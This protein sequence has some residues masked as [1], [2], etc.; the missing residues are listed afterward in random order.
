MTKKIEMGLRIRIKMIIIFR[1]KN[2]IKI[3]RRIKIKNEEEKDEDEE[4]NKDFGMYELFCRYCW[5][6]LRYLLYFLRILG[7]LWLFV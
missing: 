6:I 4:E 7:Q 1:I 3:R 2:V 5:L